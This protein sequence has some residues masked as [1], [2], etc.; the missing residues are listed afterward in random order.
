MSSCSG[1]PRGIE[2]GADNDAPV[3]SP[4]EALASFVLQ[5]GFDI[6]IAAAEPLIEDPVAIDFDAHGRIWVVEMRAFM[7]NVEGE[8]ELTP[9]GRVSVLEDLD[10]DGRMDRSSVF[11]D[12][13]VLPRAVKVLERGVLVA[14][15]PYLWLA[16]DTTGDLKADVQEAVRNDYG[17]RESNP[18]RNPNGLLWALDNWIVSTYYD[19]RL[20]VQDQGWTSMPTLDRG[21]W[22]IGMDDYG[23]LYRNWNEG[24]LYVD[25]LPAHYF[26]R[27]PNLE[28]ISG[29]YV[30][31]VDDDR[32]WPVRTNYGVNRG[33]RE[34]VL[35]EDGR[36]QA[37]TAAGSPVVFRGDRLPPDLVNDV[38]VSEPAGNLVRRFEVA[39]DSGGALRARHPYKRSEFL[40]STDERFRPVNFYSG[41][42][43]ALYVVD[44]YRGIVQHRQYLTEYLEDQI[45][46]RDLDEPVGLG[47]IYRIVHEDYPHDP[48]P[49]P[50]KMDAA[51]LV[52]Q[53][54]HANGWRRDTAQRLLIERGDTS[55]AAAL[56]GLVSRADDERT[57][58]H[59]LWTLDGL[60]VLDDATVAE[61]LDD[62]SP[63]VRAAAVRL[64]EREPVR[65]T[66]MLADDS[67]VV[68]R[69]LAASLSALTE[70]FPALERLLLA[71]GDD[72]IVVDAALSGLYG[73]EAAFLERLL[74]LDAAILGDAIAMSTAA[75]LN[76]GDESVI[77]FLEGAELAEWQ[78]AAVLEGILAFAPDPPE[79]EDGWADFEP[80]GLHARPDALLEAATGRGELAEQA[81]RA[82]ALLSWPGKPERE[83]PDV[84][85]LSDLEQDRFEK[86]A[87]L[88]LVSCA[89]CHGEDGRA[90]SREGVPLV[91]SR[92]ATGREDPL[93]RI[94]LHGKENDGLMPPMRQLSDEQIAAILTFVRRSWGNEA[95][96]ISPGEVEEVRGRTASRRRPWTEEELDG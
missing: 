50:A 35:R 19:R 21:Q 77:A 60:G 46:Q 54:S 93:I 92:W 18:E 85:P 86:G 73:R 62:S 96:A 6:E 22:G 2:T 15:P 59:A 24:P 56:R 37:F 39:A 26:A 45:E 48:G 36:L 30:D 4:E 12:S 38:F 52:D 7:P 79:G 75:A 33:Y 76:G 55:L 3:L 87:E 23:R 29:A 91:G 13:L 27:N 88:Y 84:P 64:S 58:L 71:H 28:R 80:H 41:P 95:S 81:R 72:P 51:E 44:M 31:V 5:P 65:L 1:P 14:E 40:A 68:Y 42:D 8:G 20:R 49:P 89:A 16:R 10:R 66:R 69:Q 53:L 83:R 43:G 9:N 63:Y 57:R 70:P 94:I 82:A 47:R 74:R 11:L 90:R 34:G 67:P 78:K 61:A 32:V 17:R 25:Y